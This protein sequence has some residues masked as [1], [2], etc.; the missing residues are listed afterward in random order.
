MKRLQSSSGVPGLLVTGAL[1]FLAA[2]YLGGIIM[3]AGALALGFDF[4]FQ[5]Y[6]GASAIVHGQ[7]LYTSPDDPALE[8]GKA[9]VYPPPLAA[10]LTPLTLLS[11]DTA[12][13]LAILAAIAAVWAALALVGVGDLRCYAAVVLTAPVWNVL[14]TANVTAL[15]TL[16]LALA[17]RFRS[18]VWPLACVLGVALATKLFLWPLAVWTLAT[19]RYGVT[20][21]LA[22]VGVVTLAVTWA[23]AG[24]QGVREYPDLVTRLSEIHARHSYSVRGMAAALGLGAVAGQLLALLAGGLL[25]GLC[26]VLARRRDDVGA[27][28]CAVAGALALTPILWQHY[29]CLLLV[30]LGIARPRF[31]AIWLLPAGLWIAPRVGHGSGIEPFLP[32]LVTAVTLTAILRPRT[33]V[34]SWREATV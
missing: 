20:V 25:L 26:F 1:L 30:P 10:A 6:D 22:F 13:L 19:R 16:A 7:P 15:L 27:F 18:T 24:F 17:W 23:T 2:V 8:V 14:E 32:A 29:L 9:Y 4:R 34:R 28:T 21:R 3:S 5:Y 11:R 33:S 12:T 31:S